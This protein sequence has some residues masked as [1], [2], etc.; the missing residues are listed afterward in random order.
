MFSPLAFPNGILLYDLSTSMPP[1]SHLSL[2]PF[3]LYREPMMAIGIADSEEYH[4]Q[5]SN[6]NDHDGHEGSR[7]EMARSPRDASELAEVVSDLREQYP[8]MLVHQLLLFDQA[9]TSDNSWVPEG[10][11]IVPPLRESKVTTMKT[12]IVVNGDTGVTTEELEP[13]LNEFLGLLGYV[14][15]VP[16][17]ESRSPDRLNSVEMASTIDKDHPSP[18]E[19]EGMKQDYKIAMG[20]FL[21]SSVLQT[22]GSFN[23]KL[24]VLRTCISFCEVLPDFR[25][26]LHFTAA[27]FRVVGPGRVSNLNGNDVL[28]SLAREEQMRLA[29]NMSRTIAAASKLGVRDID[30][31]YWDDFLVRG[32]QV[33]EA[34]PANV[35]IARTKSELDEERQ[36]QEQQLKGPFIYDPFAKKPDAKAAEKLLVAGESSVFVVEMQN[37][38]DFELEIESLKL[39]TEGVD[40]ASIAENLTLGPFRTQHIVLEGCAH[41][42][43]VLKITGCVVK[44]R[45]CLERTFLIFVEPWSPEPD[46]RIKGIGLSAAEALTVRPTSWVSTSPQIKQTQPRPVPTST[47]IPLTVVNQQPLIIVSH[48]SLPQSAMMIL[49]GE[50]KSFSIT[51]SN[52]SANI[53]VDFLHLSFLDSTAEPLRAAL[54]NKEL[55]RGDVHELELQAMKGPA[56]SWRRPETDAEVLTYISPG[57]SVVFD[58]EVVGKPGLTD[59]TVIFD[60]A[61]LGMPSSEIK[62]KF[63]TRRVSF[64]VTVTVNA[65]VQLH[66]LDVAPFTGD[67]AWSNQHHS[68]LATKGSDER[69]AHRRLASRATE[70][71]E[72]RFKSLLDRVGYGSNGDEHCLLLLDLRNAW[73]APLSIALQVRDSLGSDDAPDEEWRRA[74]TLHE[75]IQPGHVS[76]LVVLLPRMYLKNPHAPIP[77]LN[78][79]NQRQF[80]VNA[81]KLPL[82]QERATREAFWYREEVLKHTRGTWKEDGNDRHG[83]IELRGIRLSSRMIDAIK[84]DEITMNMTV[85]SNGDREHAARQTG[86]SR[87]EVSVDEFLTLRTR[88]YNRSALPVHSLLR[89]QPSLSHQ[90]PGS[91]LDLDRRLAWSGLLQRALPILDPGESVEEKYRV[92][93][94]K[95]PDQ[96]RSRTICWAEVDEECGMR[97]K[98]V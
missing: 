29:T 32:V 31:D 27:L 58:I 97:E 56:L 25:G 14:Y 41:A 92:L 80:I 7:G 78:P 20:N 71:G 35:P 87:F 61:N 81:N 79:A 48:V 77:V 37:P 38:Y 90:P 67:F 17:T 11:I 12:I 66:R 91:A 51:L 84:S 1:P 2:S 42:A 49:E 86:R 74:Y 46:S 53:P 76:R 65:S 4:G 54:S 52:T 82:E 8:K 33:V 22:F 55:S 39:A 34:A 57:E 18:E 70:K 5:E 83:D 59:A 36:T 40:F 60:Y 96:D 89:L 26:V 85:V 43:G 64:P 95:E 68:R 75:T 73:P 63:F 30:A 9:Q 13:G 62:D 45:G 23:L 10:A 15:G 94:R 72:N 47:I 16:Q 93:T 19:A 6:E 88:V 44:I 21:R 50:R 69:L 98:R 3:E 24:D 28:V